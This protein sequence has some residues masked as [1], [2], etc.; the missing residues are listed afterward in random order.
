MPDIRLF[1]C[2]LIVVTKVIPTKVIE[3]TKSVEVI[4]PTMSSNDVLCG[5]KTH[6][7]LTRPCANND[8]Y[9]G[10]WSGRFWKPTACVYRDITT[11]QAKKCIGNRTL[12]F[13]GDTQ[14]RD[15]ALG[16]SLFLLGKTLDKSSK[17]RFENVCI[18][19]WSIVDH[20]LPR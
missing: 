7:S 8:T 12:A 18:L 13:I 2:L 14:V 6:A 20:V 19:S 11:E 17:V 5:E 3:V 9:C 10:D 1:I 15:I 4:P 16:V